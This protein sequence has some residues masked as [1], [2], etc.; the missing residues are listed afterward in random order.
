MQG[1]CLFSTAS[2]ISATGSLYDEGASKDWFNF[3][4]RWFKGDIPPPPLQRCFK[5]A[6]VGGGSR[7]NPVGVRGRE[8]EKATANKQLGLARWKFAGVRGVAKDTAA[9]SK[10]FGLACQSAGLR[11]QKKE[12][13][14]GA[15]RLG[16]VSLQSWFGL[17]GA[18]YPEEQEQWDLC[19]PS[20]SQAVQ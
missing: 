5:I 17:W 3:E 18:T 20:Q 1:T 13:P 8:K 9:K 7:L 16:L 12:K 6:G 2:K 10:R 15:K 14:A 19:P 11:G 4:E